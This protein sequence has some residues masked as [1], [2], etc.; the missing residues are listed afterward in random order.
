[1]AASGLL[2]N[3]ACFV[4]FGAGKGNLSDL[5]HACCPESSHILIDRQAVRHKAERRFVCNEETQD[6]FTRLNIDISHLNLSAVGQLQNQTTLV[7]VAKHICGSASDLAMRC[8]AHTLGEHKQK[9]V[10]MAVA[11]CCHHRCTYNAY[12]NTEFL[13]QLG[14]GEKEFKIL[15][16]MSSWAVCKF[17]PEVKRSTTEEKKAQIDSVGWLS[18]AEKEALGIQC[19]ELLDT[20][21]AI[22][23]RNQGFDV[24][25]IR[26]VS[27][28]ISLENTLLIAHLP[29]Q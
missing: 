16:R 3:G 1:M 9:L 18:P 28:D 12:L 8:C 10:G 7:S 5:I 6:R 20:G 22:Y 4:E 25:L 11:L 17:P 24:S 26:Y 21:R 29:Q 27:P 19:K 13:G 14:I 2:I 15:C 23:L